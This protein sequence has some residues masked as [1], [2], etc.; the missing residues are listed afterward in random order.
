MSIMPETSQPDKSRESSEVQPWNI[1]L[2]SLKFEVSHSEALT[3][4]SLEQLRNVQ[5]MADV[6]DVSRFDRSASSRLVNS[7]N[8]LV[9]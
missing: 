4:E 8:R 7:L 1:Q 3:E 9:Q 6:F 2:V 5:I